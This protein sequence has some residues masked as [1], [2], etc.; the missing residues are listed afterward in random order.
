MCTFSKE[1]KTFTPKI[2]N[3]IFGK[4]LLN[5][6]FN[7]KFSS[8]LKVGN[9]KFVNFRVKFLISELCAM[10]KVLHFIFSS[11]YKERESVNLEEKIKDLTSQM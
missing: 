5:W 6:M 3:R 8:N 10:S 1:L 7:P 9:R 2:I 4:S 11:I